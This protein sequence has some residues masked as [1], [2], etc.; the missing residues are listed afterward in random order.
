LMTSAL[1]PI[2][3]FCCP[4]TMSAWW[5][6]QCIV[7]ATATLCATQFKQMIE[8]KTLGIDVQLGKT[9]PIKDLCCN[10]NAKM[11]DFDVQ[12]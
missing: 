7:H 4:E 9:H 11:I 3:C 12:P 6:I 8:N 2:K 1:P 10:W 5:K